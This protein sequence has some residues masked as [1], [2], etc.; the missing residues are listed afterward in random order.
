MQLN[1]LK[2]TVCTNAYGQKLKASRLICQ[3]HFFLT[4]WSFNFSTK[5]EIVRLVRVWFWC[6]FLF[7][8]SAL[9]HDYRISKH[10]FCF[11]AFF[12]PQWILTKFLFSFCGFL[13]PRC[14]IHTRT[15]NMCLAITLNFLCDVITSSNETETSIFLIVCTRILSLVVFVVF[16]PLS[17]EWWNLRNENKLLLLSH[18]FTH[19]LCFF[20]S[21]EFHAIF[22][23]MLK[24][25]IQFF[26]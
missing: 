6:N 25:L 19:E 12:V 10:S 26:T 3:N 24:Q 20:E 17:S 13:L 16:F 21:W 15:R 2:A 9:K 18:E 4:C 11:I 8:C 1:G 23:S 22:W 5:T 14:K 7:C